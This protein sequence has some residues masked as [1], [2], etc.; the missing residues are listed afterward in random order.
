MRKSSHHE[1]EFC[2]PGLESRRSL[3]G[4]VAIP[5]LN[6]TDLYIL[7]GS[8]SLLCGKLHSANNSRA[9]ILR[10]DRSDLVLGLVDLAGSAQLGR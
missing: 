1:Q 6:H 3:S 5:I 2:D 8:G 10:W 9:S 7:S 4:S